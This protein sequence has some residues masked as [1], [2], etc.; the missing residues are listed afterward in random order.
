MDTEEK[1][2]VSWDDVK[3]IEKNQRSAPWVVSI[4]FAICA[5]VVIFT[6]HNTVATIISIV[7]IVALFIV[8]MVLSR[9]AKDYS[10]IHFLKK[11]LTKKE[12]TAGFM[13]DNGE[14]R[15][16][17]FFEFGDLRVRASSEYYTDYDIGSQFYLMINESDNSVMSIYPED[18]YIIPGDFEV[19][20]E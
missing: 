4:F 2:V 3:Q 15:Y 7:A 6:L 8:F 19:R 13:E 20:E 1:K 14:Y 12:K 16:H 9:P 10:K 17:Y 18:K 5:V 11:A